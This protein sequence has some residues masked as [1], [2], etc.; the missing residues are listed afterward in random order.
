MVAWQP[1]CDDIDEMNLMHF[2]MVLDMAEMVIQWKKLSQ[3][4]FRLSHVLLWMMIAFFN[5]SWFCKESEPAEKSKNEKTRYLT[6]A[7]VAL[8]NANVYEK[9]LFVFDELSC[10]VLCCQVNEL[11]KNEKKKPML[12][13]MNVVLQIARARM[14]VLANLCC[15]S[16]CSKRFSRAKKRFFWWLRNH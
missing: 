7:T 14:G 3:C 10:V 1:I 2:Q 8:K 15:S 16:S 13:L 12:M 4:T 6:W 9:P 11:R 5:G